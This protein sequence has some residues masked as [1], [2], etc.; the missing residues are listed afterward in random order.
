MGQCLR[1]L[2]D[3]E[4][5]S[6]LIELPVDASAFLRRHPDAEVGF[7]V[8][9]TFRRVPPGNFN[10][11]LATFAEA[12]TLLEEGPMAQSAVTLA[13]IHALTDGISH[14]TFPMADG[15]TQHL[16]CI[17]F[18]ACEGMLYI[19]TPNEGIGDLTAPIKND[20][21]KAYHITTDLRSGIIQAD[22]D[23]ALEFGIEPE[24]VTNYALFD[25]ITKS[26]QPA[27]NDDLIRSWIQG[28]GQGIAATRL[29]L[30]ALDGSGSGWFQLTIRI[31]ENKA[32]ISL[33][34][35][36]E[37]VRASERL[38]HSANEFRALAETVPMGIFRA[39]HTGALLYKNSK[40]NRVFGMELDMRLPVELTATIDGEPLLDAFGAAF[41]KGTEAQLD[42]RLETLHS[43]PRFLRIRAT[44]TMTADGD[45][46]IV[47]SAEDITSE[48]L[49]RVQLSSD[50]LTDSLTGTANRRGLDLALSRHLQSDRQADRQ[51]AVL[52][53]DLDGFKEVN[54]DFGHDAGDAVLIEV[55]RRIDA[56]RR[57]EDVVARLGGDEFVLLATAISQPTTA[58]ELAER[59]RAAVQLPVLHNELSLD[60]SASVGV[61]L[62]QPDSTAANL[63]DLADMAMFEA[64]RAGRDRVRASRRRAA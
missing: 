13:V 21:I 26:E 62:S 19:L 3:V 10:T 60:V 8:G 24:L 55:G 48:H 16:S 61:A 36:T 14:V 33:V 45:P 49:Q 52:V 35:V 2:N 38:A 37:D 30:F 39:M 5:Q 57:E 28:L 20:P 7:T 53:I 25:L 59:I 1:R 58:L 31:V 42:V 9:P 54:D 41:E 29:Q 50:A 6:E 15:R 4:S 18:E 47:G 12:P 64:K 40:L 44:S 23:F 63:L 34:D 56:I 11:T 51:F 22:S 46:E 17:R 32:E 27:D 43:S